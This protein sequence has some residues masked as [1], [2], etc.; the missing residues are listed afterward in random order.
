M[1]AGETF[2]LDTRVRN[3]SAET[4]PIGLP[5]RVALSYRWCDAGGEEVVPEGL[6]T[7]LDEP[8]EPGAWVAAA[9]EIAAPAEPGSYVL[10]LDLV[11]ELVAWFFW[12][13]GDL[14]FRAPVEVVAGDE[15][16]MEQPEVGDR[17]AG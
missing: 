12:K 7:Y 15:P 6:R 3:A 16:E 9:Q 10:E 13:D 11:Y 2:T 8:A 5:S 1:T 4:W 17:N 14:V